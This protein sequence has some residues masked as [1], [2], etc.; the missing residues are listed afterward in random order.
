[1]IAACEVSTTAGAGNA[2]A[3]LGGGFWMRGVTTCLSDVTGGVGGGGGAAFCPDSTGLWRCPIFCVHTL[4][5]SQRGF[6][7]LHSLW[8]LYWIV[9]YAPIDVFVVALKALG[10]KIYITQGGFF[11]LS[12]YVCVYHCFSWKSYTFIFLFDN[13]FS[14]I[15]KYYT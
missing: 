13:H 14:L 4:A 5:P 8:V 7:R 9:V 6:T 10:M 1:M 12:G 11:T 15:W 2:G 3:S